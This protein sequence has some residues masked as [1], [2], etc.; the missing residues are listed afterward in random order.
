MED[1]L[2]LKK[3][4]NE[5]N[6]SVG[7]ENNSETDVCLHPEP[8]PVVDNLIIKKIGNEWKC[9]VKKKASPKSIND[10][11]IGYKHVT[12]SELI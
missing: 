3:I 5:W 10:L 11:K 8:L 7:I 9:S 2:I 12:V 6:C 1:N 4:G